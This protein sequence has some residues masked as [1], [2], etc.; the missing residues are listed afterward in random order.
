M[1]R[2]RWAQV[3]SDRKQSFTQSII[4]LSHKVAERRGCGTPRLDTWERIPE[5]IDEQIVDLSIEAGKG[6][7]TAQ[8]HSAALTQPASRISTIMMKFDAGTGDEPLVNGLISDLL[9]GLQA[10]APSEVRD[11]SYRDEGTSQATEKEG[12]EADTAKH[13]S[14]L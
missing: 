3:E 6:D 13:S 9:N 2:T 14:I 7:Q 4:N 5:H 1:M 8:E 12:L 11:T 10:E